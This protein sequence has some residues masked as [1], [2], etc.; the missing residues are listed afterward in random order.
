VTASGLMG[1]DARSYVENNPL[2]LH[3]TDAFAETCAVKTGLQ[4]SR[5]CSFCSAYCRSTL[6]NP[7]THVKP[8][9]SSSRPGA[10]IPLV[11]PIQTLRAIRL[12]V[13]AHH[14]W[15]ICW[16]DIWRVSRDAVANSEKCQQYFSSRKWIW[17]MWKWKFR[18]CLMA[19]VSS[20]TWQ[21]WRR[22]PL[23]CHTSDT[24]ARQ[25]LQ[26]WRSDH[27]L[28]RPYRTD[29]PWCIRRRSLHA[30]TDPTFSKPL[31]CWTSGNWTLYHTLSVR[32]ISVKISLYHWFCGRWIQQSYTR[33]CDQVRKQPI[34]PYLDADEQADHTFRWG[35]PECRY[36]HFWSGW[37]DGRGRAHLWRGWQLSCQ[38][39]RDRRCKYL[40]SRHFFVLERK[41]MI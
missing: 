10:R 28:P 30:D 5:I 26:A 13:S 18:I 20:W 27:L 41:Q 34:I 23:R 16:L 25:R 14:W 29:A 8:L 17:V 39:P 4:P 37:F 24:F 11:W 40:E 15:A 35:L 22:S 38:P 32:E 2:P 21:F 6:W 7:G 36:Q 9:V 1:S 33:S 12:F 19:L 3:N 31:F